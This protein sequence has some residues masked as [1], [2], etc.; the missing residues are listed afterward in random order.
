[1]AVKRK[2]R[3]QPQKGQGAE[4][5]PPP[6]NSRDLIR[7]VRGIRELLQRYICQSQTNQEKNKTDASDTINIHRRAVKWTKIYTSITAAIF[8]IAA[9][10]AYIA[11]D[12]EIVANRAFV[13]STVI[14]FITFSSKDHIPR[15]WIVTPILENVGNTQTINLHATTN[16]AFCLNPGPNPDAQVWGG[17]AIKWYNTPHSDWVYSVIGPKSERTGADIPF[18]DIKIDCGIA[19]VGL[20]LIKYSDVFGYKHL[21]EFCHWMKKTT[22]DSIDF[23]NYS[24]DQSIRWTG[25]PCPYH[26]C[27]D[28]ECGADW[29]ERAADLK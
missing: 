16:I 14:R 3:G 29:Q 13:I 24:L 23:Q 7:Y 2:N 19:V 18:A 6:N 9:V 20:G 15:E 22:Y 27:A 11:R 17:K 10:Q 26:N 5:H 1:M 4:H 8:I 12:T 25:L 28:K 21:V